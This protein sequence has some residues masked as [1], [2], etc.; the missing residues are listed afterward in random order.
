MQGD[1]AA[2]FM[3]EKREVFYG[4]DHAAICFV[5]R[6]LPYL[7]ILRLQAPFGGDMEHTANVFRGPVRHQ[8]C[9]HLPAPQARLPVPNV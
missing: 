1:F 4:S 7:E 8:Q 2:R 6:R 9:H 3:K 5:M